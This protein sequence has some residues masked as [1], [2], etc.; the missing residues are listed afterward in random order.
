MTLDDADMRRGL[1]TYEAYTAIGGGP[2]AI[3][4]IVVTCLLGGVFLPVIF[5]YSPLDLVAKRS[6][7]NLTPVSGSLVRERLK[8]LPF[9]TPGY[10]PLACLT[11]FKY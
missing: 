5:G 4:P 10:D 1:Q 7:G 8:N 9:Y 3:V 2:E 6:L 11:A